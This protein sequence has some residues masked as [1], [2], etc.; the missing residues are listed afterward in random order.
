MP[1]FSSLKFDSR[2]NFGSSK[3]AYSFYIV[4]KAQ[5]SSTSVVGESVPELS[6]GDEA[7]SLTAAN[8]SIVQI[9]QSCLFDISRK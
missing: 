3:L 8:R 9:R 6:V 4:G 5:E 7:L 1:L 2:E